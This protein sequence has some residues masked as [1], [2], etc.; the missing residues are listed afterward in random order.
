MDRHFFIAGDSA[1]CP[2]RRRTAG[3][4]VLHSVILKFRDTMGNIIW[5]N[6]ALKLCKII[7]REFLSCLLRFS[8][9]VKDIVEKWQWTA[10]QPSTHAGGDHDSFSG[11]TRTR[12]ILSLNWIDPGRW[13]RRYC[14]GALLNSSCNRISE[15]ALNDF[16]NIRGPI[17][18]FWLIF[19]Q[20]LASLRGI[21]EQGIR[22]ID[23]L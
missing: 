16:L 20:E 1:A 22:S 8:G 23:Y 21:I 5:L 11:F 18:F 6:R 7:S 14:M 15:I 9:T 13:R 19:L 2:S 12:R 4:T 17:G 3:I 10:S